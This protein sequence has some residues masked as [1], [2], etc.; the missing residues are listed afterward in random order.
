[1]YL[2]SHSVATFKYKCIILMH[3]CTNT[4]FVPCFLLVLK[5]S[6]ENAFT[7]IAN[8]MSKIFK[9]SFRFSFLLLQ[10]SYQKCAVKYIKRLSLKHEN[11]DEGKRSSSFFRGWMLQVYANFYFPFFTSSLFLFSL[12]VIK[13]FLHHVSS[14]FLPTF[15]Y[16]LNLELLLYLMDFLHY[17]CRKVSWPYWKLW[18][19]K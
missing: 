5:R 17:F 4:F 18:I 9:C 14:P 19:Q 12:K 10:K 6:L 13:L 11:D 15:I 7:F 3:I 8:K 1:M 16:R 2:K